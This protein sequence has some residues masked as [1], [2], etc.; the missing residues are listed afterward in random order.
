M[1]NLVFAI[2]PVPS[3]L[4]YPASSISPLPSRLCHPASSIAPLPTLACWSC[5]PLL[6]SRI[7]TPVQFYLMRKTPRKASP[8]MTRGSA[9]RA[10]SIAHTSQLYPTRS[11]W[12]GLY[13]CFLLVEFCML[14]W[15]VHT[16]KGEDECRLYLF[17]EGRMKTNRQMN[18]ALLNAICRFQLAS[19][20]QI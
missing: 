1:G 18:C 14:V 9:G 12:A 10:A 8:P 6:F 17:I 4:F 5:A 13:K 3:R 7:W 11:N 2:P 16:I 20:S 19:L 15:S